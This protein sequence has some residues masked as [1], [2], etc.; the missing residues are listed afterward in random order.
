[1]TNSHIVHVFAY[2][3]KVVTMERA[4]WVHINRKS[5]VLASSSQYNKPHKGIECK[6]YQQSHDHQFFFNS[7]L[8]FSFIPCFHIM[9]CRVQ[10]PQAT[11]FVMPRMDDSVKRYS[12]PNNHYPVWYI[13]VDHVVILWCNVTLCLRHN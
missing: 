13:I 5:P 7:V 1:M 10:I 2:V 11:K 8:I 6:V 4:G 3:T 12:K 9:L